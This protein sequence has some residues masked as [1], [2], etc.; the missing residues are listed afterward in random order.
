MKIL[1]VPYY[2]YIQYPVFQPVI[3]ALNREG[4]RA[5]LLHIPNI[6]ALDETPIFNAERFEADAVPFVALRL[7]RSRRPRTLVSLERGMQFHANTHLLKHQLQLQRPDAVVIGSHLGGIYIRVLLVVCQ[8][9]DIPVVSLYTT[10]DDARART[11]LGW[12]RKL[13]PSRLARRVLDWGPTTPA[14]RRL[15][16]LVPGE[17]TR[18]RL[19]ER[20]IDGARICVTGNPAH[21]HLTGINC[22]L[23]TPRST[24]TLLYVSEV[25]QEVRGLDYLGHALRT[26]RDSILALQPKPIVRVRFHPRE[27]AEVRQLHRELLQPLVPEFHTEEPFDQS[28]R[29]VTVAIGHYSAALELLLAAGVPV[30]SLLTSDLLEGGLYDGLRRKAECRSGAEL[31]AL[32]QGVMNRDLRVTELLSA[33]MAEF[34]QKHSFAIDGQSASRVAEQIISAARGKTCAN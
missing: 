27:S 14:V 9:L 7:K 5:L 30:V 28:V 10:K 29:S 19:V 20:G 25:I 6:S 18:E 12:V 21:D 33:A 17:A 1:F 22:G 26:L 3:L 31:T 13:I 23:S 24:T 2:L 8:H 11:E 32:L 16:F 15:T 34:N 4:A